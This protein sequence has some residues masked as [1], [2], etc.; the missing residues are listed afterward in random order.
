MR[1]ALALIG[2]GV[3]IAATGIALISV[4]AAV[5]FLGVAVAA[6]GTVLTDVKGSK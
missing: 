2:A 4:P 5:I 3:V 6:V 1:K